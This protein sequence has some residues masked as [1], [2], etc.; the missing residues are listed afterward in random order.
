MGGG[1]N[2]RRGTRDGGQARGRD[3]HKGSTEAPAKREEAVKLKKRKHRTGI[4]EGQA[5]R[6]SHLVWFPRGAQD[7][8]L[9]GLSLPGLSLRGK[10]LLS[11]R[12]LRLNPPCSSTRS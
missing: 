3:K 7:C 9:R 5:S 6:S 4:Q 1:E 10:G 12:G 11:P 8:L 2:Q